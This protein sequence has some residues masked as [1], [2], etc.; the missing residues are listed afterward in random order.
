MAIIH[1]KVQVGVAIACANFFI[2]KARIAPTSSFGAAL[3]SFDAS[4]NPVRFS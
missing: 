4:G 2:R 3:S 1:I